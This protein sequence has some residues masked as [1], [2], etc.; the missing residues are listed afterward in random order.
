M[1]PQIAAAPGTVKKYSKI[2]PCKWNTEGSVRSHDSEDDDG[3]PVGGYAVLS[4]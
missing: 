2:E 3:C 4:A 1:T